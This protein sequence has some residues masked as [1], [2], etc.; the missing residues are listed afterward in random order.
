MDD[1]G[2][3]FPGRK[4]CIPLVQRFSRSVSSSAVPLQASHGVFYLSQSRHDDLHRAQH[5]R[6]NASERRPGLVA[7]ALA[8]GPQLLG[9]VQNARLQCDDA[10]VPRNLWNSAVQ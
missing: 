8:K 4:R 2:L 6:E 9:A 5:I 3:S 1:L 7:A 10:L